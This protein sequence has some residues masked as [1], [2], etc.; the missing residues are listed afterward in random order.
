LSPWLFPFEFSTLNYVNQYSFL[1]YTLCPYKTKFSDDEN[2]ILEAQLLKCSTHVSWFALHF[3][4]LLASILFIY[5][6]YIVIMSR[7]ILFH[8]IPNTTSHHVPKR[9]CETDTNQD[10]FC[11]IATT[12]SLL[13]STPEILFSNFIHA[14]SPYSCFDI[15]ILMFSCKN[16]FLMSFWADILFCFVFF[17]LFGF[18]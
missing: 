10:N 11:A 6:S 9:R 2:I 1:F 15:F 17:I 7:H 4:L 3:N 12:V 5:P 14:F 8:D 18:L 16:S 13:F